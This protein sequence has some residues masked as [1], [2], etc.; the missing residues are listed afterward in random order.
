MLLLIVSQQSQLQDMLKMLVRPVNPSD[1]QSL[2][3]IYN[4]YVLNTVS[5]FETEPV[6]VEIMEQR[7]LKVTKKFPWLVC[8]DDIY[9]LLVG[10][11]YADTYKD[12]AAWQGTVMR[13]TWDRRGMNIVLLIKHFKLMST[14]NFRCR[15]WSLRKTVGH[16]RITKLQNSYSHYSQQ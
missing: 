15:C 16:F 2:V 1:Y 14:S 4:H 10:F 12:R 11:A 3:D 5:T 7:V 9:N 6:S 13:H 8:V